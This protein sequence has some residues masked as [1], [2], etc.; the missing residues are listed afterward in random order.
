MELTALTIAGSDPSGGAGIQQ[1]LKTF[2]SFR[3]HGA[4]AI[5]AVTAQN[6]RKVSDYL[7]LPLDLIEKQIDAV[8]QDLHV[9]AAKTGMLANAEVINLVKK[10]IREYNIKNLVV[11]PVMVATS[12]DVLLDEKAINE[13]RKLISIARIS[14]PNIYEAE[15]L[16]GIKIKTIN[17]MQKAADEL[18]NTVVKGGHLDA[19]DVL[20]YN[21]EIILY[22]SRI[23][24]KDIKLHGAGCAFSAAIAASLAR[25]KSV[26]EAVAEAKKYMDSAIEKYL[27]VGQGSYVL[28]TGNIKLSETLEDERKNRVL[29]NIEQ[30]IN[31]FTANPQAYRL[32][33]E[34]GCNI[35]MALPGARKLGETA[36]L[37]GRLVKAE[38]Q[39]V[40]AG[41]VKFRGSL[42]MARVVLKAMEYDKEK[43][44]ALN[45]KHS[46]E[47]IDACREHYVTASFDR[48]QEPPSTGTMEWGT[49]KAIEAVGEFPDVIYD[50]GGIGKEAMIR[51]LGYDAVEVVKKALVIAEILK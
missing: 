19:V 45:I 50:S 44:A 47:I 9:K 31:N 26:P 42:H 34:V 25:E 24:R 11:D 4:T 30:A 32:I 49:H 18:G 28:D 39:V 48:I 16:S 38:R 12:G 33:P 46:T 10:K 36:G 6:T 3:V 17:D 1:D 41:L 20:S 51:I 29:D 23:G 37:S 13:M 15:T 22:K 27:K 5:T 35:A 7:I 14:T 2:N 40:P 8:M 21:G 43:R